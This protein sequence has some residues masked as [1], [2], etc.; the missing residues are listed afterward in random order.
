MNWINHF[1][2]LITKFPKRGLT[3]RQDK[4]MEGHKDLNAG[5]AV[6]VFLIAMI[7]L[8]ARCSDASV[9][10]ALS[11]IGLIFFWTLAAGEHCASA[12]K[13]LTERPG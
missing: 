11:E 13:C 10:N 1:Y 9:S 4:G 8:L 2:T 7:L 3:W 12:D 6:Y 5:R